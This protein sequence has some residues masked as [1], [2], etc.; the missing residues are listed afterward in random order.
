MWRGDAVFVGKKGSGKTTLLLRWVR[1]LPGPAIVWDANGSMPHPTW[2]AVAGPDSDL[3]ALRAVLE[4]GGKVLFREGRIEPD[5]GAAS[6]G[7]VR[8]HMLAFVGLCQVYGAS[9]AVDEAHEAAAQSREDPSLLDLIRRG[10]HFG[11]RGRD[12]RP[13]GASFALATT[14]PQELSK[15]P[16]HAGAVV[17]L[18]DAPYSRPWLSTYGIPAGAAEALR[19]APPHSYLRIR[20]GVADGPYLGPAGLAH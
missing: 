18:F 3:G 19:A 7:T 1:S 13:V 2:A 20:E 10:R 5:R 8:R 9:L 17:Y 15:A 16:M 6:P 11:P 4:A 14:A 12:G